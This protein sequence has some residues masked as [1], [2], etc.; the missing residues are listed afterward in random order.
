MATLYN[1]TEYIIG[2]A[3]LDTFDMQPGRIEP[4]KQKDFYVTTWLPSNWIPTTAKIHAESDEAVLRSPYYLPLI[5]DHTRT[6]DPQVGKIPTYFR[7]DITNTLRVDQEFYWILQIKKM[8][9]DEYDIQWA[10]EQSITEHIEVV[11]SNVLSGSS[12]IID[13]KWMPEQKGRYFYEI[14]I[15]SSLGSPVPLSHPREYGFYTPTD[16]WVSK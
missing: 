9:E 1:S 3:G 7:S 11:H 5:P 16:I 15:W 10:L 14:F 8:P 2:V 13:F 6:G 12:R 4:M